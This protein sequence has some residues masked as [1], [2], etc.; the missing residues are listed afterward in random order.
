M[1]LFHVPAHLDFGDWIN[2]CR[3]WGGGRGGGRVC[4]CVGG[5]VVGLMQPCE[6]SMLSYEESW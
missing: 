2:F 6:F 1:A 4:V 3:G 5:V